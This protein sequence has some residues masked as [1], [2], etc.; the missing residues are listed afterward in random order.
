MDCF[1]CSSVRSQKTWNLVASEECSRI[2]SFP[3][4]VLYPFK[5]VSIAR[6]SWSLVY[7][8]MVLFLTLP[9]S[10]SL[11]TVRC[12]GM[13]WDVLLTSHLPRWSMASLFYF[14]LFHLLPFR[15]TMAFKE[16]YDME[17]ICRHWDLT[18][19][20]TRE[21]FHISH[22][23]IPESKLKLVYTVFVVVAEGE[24]HFIFRWLRSL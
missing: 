14:L 21:Y 9:T 20:L 22:Y 23:I 3:P 2:C 16:T 17:I 6:Y 19:T 1:Q 15:K 13:N 4:G 11:D 5:K 10:Q 7:F 24:V 12:W 18:A 8:S